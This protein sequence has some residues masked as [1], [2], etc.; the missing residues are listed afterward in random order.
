MWL[1]P[2]PGGTAQR[3]VRVE[4]SIR[5]NPRFQVPN[6]RFPLPSS[7]KAHTRVG[8]QPWKESPGDSNDRLVELNTIMPS[9]VDESA[10]QSRP[11][12]EEMTASTR[13]PCR[14][15]ETVPP[16]MRKTP[17]PQVLTQRPPSRSSV[18]PVTWLS[19]M[20]GTRTMA[21]SWYRYRPLSVPIHRVWPVSSN[22]TWTVP[23][24]PSGKSWWMASR[25]SKLSR[26]TD[27][28]TQTRP[29]WS[30]TMARTELDERPS[31]DVM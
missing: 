8:A 30:W 4:A 18:R 16:V 23:L 19:G 14:K 10:T 17:W 3:T 6:Q 22:R 13:C 21:F 28:P 24:S 20:S 31:R 26:P 29:R 2:F 1:R 9:S 15:P 7:S 27:V 12:P 11:S 25:P 5:Y